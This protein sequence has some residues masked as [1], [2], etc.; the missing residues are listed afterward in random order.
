M[1]SVLA[2]SVVDRGFICGVMVSVLASSVVYRGFI[3]GVM[4]S[5]LASSV[6]DRGFIGGVMVSVLASSV[7]D[8]GFE[9]QSCQTKDYEIGMCCFSA[10]NA[11]LREKSKDWLTRNQ[12]NMSKWDDM[13]NRG[14]LF[15]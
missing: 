7:V 8:R 4:V 5:V 6:V 12:D 15:Q 2:S 14:L 13:S 11:A 3:C 9:L 1:V 10:K